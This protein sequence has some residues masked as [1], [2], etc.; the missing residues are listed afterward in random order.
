METDV[1]AIRDYPSGRILDV[2][3][4]WDEACDIIEAW[5]DSDEQ[6][7]IYAPGRYYITKA[8]QTK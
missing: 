3:D 4:S 5:E 2:A 7:G 6:D 8:P 1:F